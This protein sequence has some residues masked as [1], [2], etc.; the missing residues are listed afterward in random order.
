M[1]Y[2]SDKQ[3]MY[4]KITCMLK[5]LFRHCKQ[6]ENNHHQTCLIEINLF[7]NPAQTK[8]TIQSTKAFRNNYYGF[9]SYIFNVFS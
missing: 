6:E 2:L 1:E 3:N 7:E 5:Y 9:F 8:G 4:K